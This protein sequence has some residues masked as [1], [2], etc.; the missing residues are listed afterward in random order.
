TCTAMEEPFQL[1]FL[2]TQRFLHHEI[3]LPS[4][5]ASIANFVNHIERPQRTRTKI[6]SRDII[7]RSLNR[8]VLQA[9]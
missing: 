1:G 6:K 8:R 2:K 4:T 9:R 3:P 5:T 7:D